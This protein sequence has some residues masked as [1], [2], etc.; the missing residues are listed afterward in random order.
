MIQPRVALG[1]RASKP[2]IRRPQS[3]PG[4][5][6]M[7]DNSSGEAE[8]TDAAIAGIDTNDSLHGTRYS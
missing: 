4:G 7:F 1:S 2:V 5:R 3:A 8:I 6:C